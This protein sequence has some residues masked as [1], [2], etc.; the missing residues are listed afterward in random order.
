MNPF[1]SKLMAAGFLLTLSVSPAFAQ[2][3]RF[4]ELQE[5][6]KFDNTPVK[7]I[8]GVIASYAPALENATPAVVTVFRKT[9]QFTQQRRGAPT[10]R[11]EMLQQLLGRGGNPGGTQQS[12]GLGSGVIL[13]ADGYILTNNHVIDGA[14]RITVALKDSRKEYEAVVV[15]ADKDT[16]V[17]LIKIEANNLTPIIIGD[18]SKVRVGDVVLAVGNPLGLEQTVTQGIVSA[19]GRRNTGITGREGYENFI[20]TDAS[21]NVG[22][23]GGALIDSQGRLVGM[24]TA[25]KTDGFSRGNV[26]IAFAIPSNM[27]VNM[28]RKLLDGGG[29]A[30]RGYLGIYLKD[31]SE[32]EARTLGRNNLKGALVTRVNPGTP[33]AAARLEVGDVIVA[34][35]G[36]SIDDSAQL[37]LGVSGK[38]PGDRADFQIFRNGVGRNISVVLGDLDN[39]IQPQQPQQQVFPGF[40]F[41][42]NNNRGIPQIR[43][44]QPQP[45]PQQQQ[46][47]RRF[48]EPKPPYSNSSQPFGNNIDIDTKLDSSFISGVTIKELTRSL[49]SSLSLDPSMQGIYVESVAPNS[50]ASEHGL[51]PGFVITQ[52]DQK[53]VTSVAEANAAVEAF[54]GKVLLLQVY[55]NGKPTILAI[56]AN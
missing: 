6:M 33:A 49:K 21:V 9:R 13:S 39:L 7:A 4:G 37:R 44:P 28:V 56:P 43:I 23:S 48:N 3:V 32:N 29:K 17:A 30:R 15:G 40:N 12:T 10:T 31:L 8:N 55:R 19:L 27:A 1:Y 2:N 18:S 5:K 26:G 50:S 42:N 38:D 47:P 11:E 36:R 22:N 16:D 54:E 41:G 24:N 35:D 52:I 25:I 14:Q 34:M 46:R 45:Q 53:K 20:Q 51:E